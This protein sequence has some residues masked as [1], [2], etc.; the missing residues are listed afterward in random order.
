MRAKNK[1]AC[2]PMRLRCSSFGSAAHITPMS[3]RRLCHLRVDTDGGALPDPDVFV[4]SLRE[5]FDEVIAS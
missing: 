4:A 5:G 2:M 3:Y 1:S